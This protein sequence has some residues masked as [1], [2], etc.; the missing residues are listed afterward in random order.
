MT[1]ILRAPAHGDFFRKE[2]DKFLDRNLPDIVEESTIEVLVGDGRHQV[3]CVSFKDV[4]VWPCVTTGAFGRMA[5]TTPEQCMLQHLTYHA[6]VTV[7]CEHRTTF[8]NEAGEQERST[9]RTYRELELFRIPQMVKGGWFIVNGQEKTIVP[10]LKLRANHVFVFPGKRFEYVAEIRSLHPTKFRSTS[11]LRIGWKG[12]IVIILPFLF[13]SATMPLEIGLSSIFTLLRCEEP[14][15]LFRRADVRAVVEESLRSDPLHGQPL[16]EVL[17]WVGRAG[18]TESTNEKRR[19]YLSHILHN[20]TLPHLGM[21]GA[22]ENVWGRKATFLS[23]MVRRLVLVVLGEQ[24]HTDRDS[25]TV[26]KV[27]GPGALTSNLF[28]QVFRQFTKTLHTQ[29]SKNLNAGKVQVCIND[30]IQPARLTNNIE[31]HFRTGNWSLTKDMNMGMV[32]Q[33]SRMNRISTLS[34]LGRVN[35]PINKQNSKNPVPR[36][37]HHSNFGIFCACETPEGVGCGLTKNLTLFCVVSVGLSRPFVFHER[38]QALFPERDLHPFP[39]FVDGVPTSSVPDME[40]A[41]QR[42]VSLR[43]NAWLGPQTSVYVDRYEE[44]LHVRTCAGRM[45]RP[46]VVA[47]RL[48]ALNRAIPGP[49]MLQRMVDAGVVEYLDKNE[50]EAHARVGV[51]HL[52]IHGL[53]ILGMAAALIPF[54]EHNQAPRN[55]YQSSMGKQAIGAPLVGKRADLHAFYLNYL[56]RPLVRSRVSHGPLQTPGIEAIVA[57][58]PYSGQNQEDA[59]VVNKSAVDRGFGW[60]TYVHTTTVTCSKTKGEMEF[61]GAPPEGGLVKGRKHAN[62]ENLDTDGFPQVGAKVQANDVIVQKYMAT[63]EIDENGK[64]SEFFRDR[65][66]LV[67]QGEEGTVEDVILTTNGKNEAMVHVKLRQT[68]KPEIGDKFCLTPDHDVLTSKGW[69]GVKNVTLEDRVCCLDPSNDTISYRRPTEV[70]L[71]HCREEPVYHVESQQVDLLTTMDHRMYVKTRSGA[72][73]ELT[74]AKHIVH[75]RVRY[76]KAS[77]GLEVFEDPPTVTPKVHHESFLLLVGIWYAEG[78]VNRQKDGWVTIVQHKPRVQK[79]VLECCR[80]LGLHGNTTKCMK[81]HIY[82]RPLFELLEPLSVGAIHKSLP[83][84]CFRLSAAHSRVLM[85]GLMLGDG[86]WRSWEYFTFSFKLKD[87]VQSLALH[88]GWSANVKLRTP[89]TIDEPLAWQVGIVRKKNSPQVNTK[90]KHDGIVSYTGTVHCVSVPPDAVFYVR[91]NGK[92]V[93]TGNSSRHGQKGTVGLIVPQEDLPFCPFTGLVPDVC[94]NPLA[95]P[96][97]M[98]IAQL[99]ECLL[100]KWCAGKGKVGDGTAFNP[101]RVGVEDIA[102]ALEAEGFSKYGKQ[103]MCNGKTGEALPAKVFIGPTF[104]Q[105]LKHLAR[106]KVYSRDK[107]LGV[108]ALNRQPP[109]GRKKKGG[110]RFG[111][112]ERDCVCAHGAAMFLND[113]LFTSS[114]KYEVPVCETCGSLACPAPNQA[115]GQSMYTKARCVQCPGSTVRMAKIPYATKTLIQ[116][117][118]GMGVGVSLKLNH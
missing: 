52:E 99:L 37:L 58:F 16:E 32:Q 68:R 4:T 8:C 17:K 104:Y 18:T 53:A 24:P 47:E 34:Q 87:D 115:Y 78:W 107:R 101:R 14:L 22:D 70:H 43:R 81:V 60:K 79:V 109:E 96:S 117:L 90:K 113:R 111:E 49:R 110:L 86:S 28:R 108:T 92:S 2:W 91:R 114:D 85:K 48:E 97:R 31:Y 33:V 77:N 88:C 25:V 106:D 23:K 89:Y 71:F 12:G 39:L 55:I 5:Y 98:T 20:E 67:K 10:Q 65:S 45:L 13:K 83:D 1:S 80:L 35:T 69:V 94:V 63:V 27:V 50:E 82:C 54:S 93:W 73:F 30:Y 38:V 66:V 26:Q 51:T 100:G 44:V 6:P 95:L 56:Q 59:I 64:Q 74:K 118:G 103:V 112:M 62:Y 105:C 42:L 40:A 7:T 46:L 9:L 41:R 11:T 61:F 3:H 36:M 29:I 15:L 102:L 84:W 72:K 75:K 57:I 116:E 21:R 19:K 76:K